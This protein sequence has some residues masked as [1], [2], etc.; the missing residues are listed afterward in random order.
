LSN[1]N[2]KPP[3]TNVKPPPHKRKAPTHKRKAPLLTTWGGYVWVHRYKS[4]PG[5]TKPRRNAW[6]YIRWFVNSIFSAF[7]SCWFLCDV[8]DVVSMRRHCFYATSQ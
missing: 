3:F 4:W 7:L 5:R 8:T 6:G 1:L 2:V